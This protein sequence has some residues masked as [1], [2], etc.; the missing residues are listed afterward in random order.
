MRKQRSSYFHTIWCEDIHTTFI[1]EKES[2]SNVYKF[3]STS[4]FISTQPLS[5]IIIA[6]RPFLLVKRSAQRAVAS[7]NFLASSGFRPLRVQPLSPAV[8]SSKVDNRICPAGVVGS[9]RYFSEESGVFFSGIRD[10]ISGKMESR[11]DKLEKDNFDLYMKELLKIL[12]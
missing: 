3:T 1:W 9:R 6:M 7:T 5:S 11:Q 10:K 12:Q 2:S 4:I 8:I